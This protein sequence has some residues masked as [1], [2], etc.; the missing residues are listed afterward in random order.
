[1]AAKEAKKHTVHPSAYIHGW[2][3]SRE[4]ILLQAMSAK[5]VGVFQEYYPAIFT[6]GR[7]CTI[8]FCK[9]RILSC[10]FIRFLE[11][12][13][14]LP[15]NV[16]QLLGPNTISLRGPQGVHAVWCQFQHGFSWSKPEYV[17]RTGCPHRVLG[18]RYLCKTRNVVVSWIIS[19][20][21]SKGRPPVLDVLHNRASREV[22]QSIDGV[23]IVEDMNPRD[24]TS[25]LYICW[26][27]ERNGC[28]WKWVEWTPRNVPLS[29]WR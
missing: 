11:E 2:S 10:I 9:N 4:Y 14:S 19:V 6:T 12:G 24:R 22:L 18:D 28:P 3:R 26:R 25:W 7:I 13:E 8:S 20:I 15:G 5:N 29:R 27:E 17:H 21:V 1:M 16:E 23:L